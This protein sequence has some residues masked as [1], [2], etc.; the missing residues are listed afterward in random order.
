MPL[1]AAKQNNNCNNIYSDIKN[2]KHPICYT[3]D[4][5]P[6]SQIFVSLVLALSLLLFSHEELLDDLD[7]L[8]QEGGYIS[9]RDRVVAQVFLQSVVVVSGRRGSGR[10]SIVQQPDL[11]QF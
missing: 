9:L 1:G 11:G 4:D 8:Q 2:K 10:H 3:S 6:F 7:L 5:P